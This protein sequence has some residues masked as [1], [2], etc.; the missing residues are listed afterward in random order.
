MKVSLR[1]VA[2]ASCKPL[3]AN[4]GHGVECHADNVRPESEGK[5]LTPLIAPQPSALWT[6]PAS[7][8][9]GLFLRPQN[10]FHKRQ[11]SH[12]CLPCS[13]DADVPDPFTRRVVCI[14]AEAGMRARLQGQVAL[15]ATRRQ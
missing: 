12:N 8:A 15:E 11:A 10:A 7:A 14:T 13:E 3:D 2:A 6:A 5:P 4:R 1:P 9:K